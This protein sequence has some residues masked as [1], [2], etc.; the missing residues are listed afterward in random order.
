MESK[1]C[2]IKHSKEGDI[3]IVEV[4]GDLHFGVVTFVSRRCIWTSAPL[5]H[6]T[7]LGVKVAAVPDRQRIYLYEPFED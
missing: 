5:E 2:N 7:I 6:G 1:N 3:V 4:A